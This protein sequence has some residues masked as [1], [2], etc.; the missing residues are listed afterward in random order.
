VP[1]R[2]DV[3]AAGVVAWRPGRE[4]LLV[5]RPRYDD[6]SFPKGKLDPGETAPA[7]A[8]REVQEETGVRVRLGPPLPEQ[9]YAVVAG[10]K[11]VHYW[12]GWPLGDHDVSGYRPNA[13]IDAVA[14][15]P[16][17]EALERLTY[18]HDRQTL[19]AAVPVRRPTRALVVL[20]HGKAVARSSWDRDDRE[21][22]LAALGL[23]QAQR[24][25][26]LLEAWDAHRVVTSSSTRCVQTVEPYAEANGRRVRGTDALSEEDA[27]DGTVDRIVSGLL[28]RRRGAVLCTHRPVLPDVL[29]AVGVRPEPVDPGGFVVVHH[30]HGRTVAAELWPAP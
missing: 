17:E 26:P 25:V 29:R 27:T 9:T 3:T 4:V 15:V 10:R 6:W 20:R 18:R 7:A 1:Q 2:A 23:A 16:H 8:V 24:L 12:V 14:W 11:V 19:A 22:P 28:E 13:E 30:R 21:R 5:H